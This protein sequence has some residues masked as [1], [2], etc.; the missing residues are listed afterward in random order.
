MTGSVSTSLPLCSG[1]VRCHK[2]KPGTAKIGL[3]WTY[4]TVVETPALHRRGQIAAEKACSRIT[5]TEAIMGLPG[6]CIGKCCKVFRA[7]LKEAL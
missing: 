1:S 3:G 5:E 2:L 4:P 6:G 7:K